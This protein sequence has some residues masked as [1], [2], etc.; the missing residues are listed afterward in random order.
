MSGEMRSL[1]FGMSTT[2]GQHWT[3]AQQAEAEACQHPDCSSYADHAAHLVEA[4]MTEA[5]N[6]VVRKHPEMFACEIS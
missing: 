4:A 2:D 3:E 5:A 6:R 1:R